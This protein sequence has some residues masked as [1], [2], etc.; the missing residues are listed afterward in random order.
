M[1]KRMTKPAS[2]RLTGKRIDAM[3]AGR[4]MDRLVAKATGNPV[5]RYSD[6]YEYAWGALEGFADGHEMHADVR[7]PFGPGDPFWAGLTPMNVTGWNGRSDWRASGETMPLAVCRAILR[8][9][10]CKPQ[11]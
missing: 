4:E 7:T 5:H 11:L 10:H 2:Q 9:A 8:A 1:S 3:P 6:Q